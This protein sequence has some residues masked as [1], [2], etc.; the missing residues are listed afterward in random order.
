[1]GKFNIQKLIIEKEAGP[2]TRALRKRFWGKMESCR[3]LYLL[4]LTIV[5]IVGLRRMNREIHWIFTK[6]S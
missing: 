2:L 4:L 5:T 6:E 3:S 1:M